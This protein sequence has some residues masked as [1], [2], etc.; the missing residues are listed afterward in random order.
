MASKFYMSGAKG[1]KLKV[2]KSWVLTLT[3]VEVTGEK[4]E[5]RSGGRMGIFG[6]PS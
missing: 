6:S 2:R 1:L 3:F 4:V 5:R